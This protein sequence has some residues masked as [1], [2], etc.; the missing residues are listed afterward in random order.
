MRE[1]VIV[2]V[3]R[4]PFGKRKGSLAAINPVDLATLPLKALVERTGIDPVLVDDV[5][6]GCVTQTGEQGT[7]VSRA[8]VLAAG[9]PIEVSGVALNRFCGSGQQA[10]NY[11]AM[12][13]LAGQA[14]VVV[15]AGLEHM[16]RVPMGADFGTPAE[17]LIDRYDLIPQGLSAELIADQWNFSREDLDRFAARSQDRY[18]AAKAAG[19]YKKAVAPVH[20]TMKDGTVVQLAEDEHPRPGTTAESLAA[21]KPSFKPEGKIHAGNASGIVDGSAAALLMTPAKAKELGLKPRARIVQTAVHGSD[22][23]LMLTGP[24]PST[25]KALKL[26][27]MTMNQIDRIEINE[28]FASVPLATMHDLE[29]DPD[30]VNIWG[31]AITHGHPLGA[32]GVMLMGKVVE[33][34]ED[35]G[36]RYGLVTMCIGM[37]MGITTIVERC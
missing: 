3:V 7:N 9:W 18:A 8:A 33:Q 2:D 4:T 10:V 32:T 6:M 11:A 28:A 27:G 23:I 20:Y 37:G 19:K 25:R 1:A 14:D 34:L 22:P 26:A 12:Q 21:L 16:T 24:I 29:M 35:E 36:L 15:A 31:G 30:K 5:I 17:Q 13:I